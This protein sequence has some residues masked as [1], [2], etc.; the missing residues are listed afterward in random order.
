MPEAV[1]NSK[2]AE[3]RE[4]GVN[5]SRYLENRQRVIRGRGQVAFLTAAGHSSYNTILVLAWLLPSN[6]LKRIKPQQ[7][8]RKLLSWS[9]YCVPVTIVQLDFIRIRYFFCYYLD[10]FCDKIF[11]NSR[12]E[13]RFSDICRGFSYLR[14]NYGLKLFDPLHCQ[15]L[16]GVDVTT[17]FRICWI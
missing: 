12:R 8:V 6:D 13:M 2:N 14:Y 4:H 9:L 15:T 5:V 7:W 3:N 11:H 17:P 1:S 16:T 10:R